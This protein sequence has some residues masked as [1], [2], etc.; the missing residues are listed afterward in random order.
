VAGAVISRAVTHFFRR[1]GFA[2]LVSVVL[3]VYGLEA[4]A[5]REA[6]VT[7]AN[8]GDQAAYL[9]YAKQMHDS[10]YTVVGRRNRMPVFPFLLSL[11][12]RPGLSE[13]QFLTRA[14]SFSIDLSILIL[15]LLFLIFRRFFPPFYA[16]ALLV[17]A[18]F[19]VFVYRSGIVQT[20]VLF[21]FLSFCSFLLLVRML[22]APRWWLAILGG[23]ATGIA[24]LTKASVLPALGLW[25]VVFLAQSSW[26]YRAQPDTRLRE[27]LRRFGLLLLV[28]GTFG[29]VIFPYIRTSKQIFGHYFYNVN[30]TFYMWCDSWPEAVA[31][32]KAYDNS[33][34]GRDFPRDLVPSPGK[35]WREHSAAQIA[36]RLGHGSKTLATRSAK[37][38]GYYKFALLFV[39]TAAALALGRRQLARRLIAEKPFAA[40]FCFLFF[41]SYVLLYAWY[42]AIVSDSRFILSLF[43]PFVF[44]ASTLVLGLGKDRTFAIAG[45]R[46]SFMELFAGCLISLAL[47]DVVYN[48]LR[49]CRLMT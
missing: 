11:N 40:I 45:R 29:A 49:I 20:E 7:P 10:G 35:Y 44:V 34:G 6:I 37:A 32:T 22:I 46:I 24:H 42:D 48:A 1:G 4:H 30:S 18:A 27:A 41:F 39:L 23:A 19:S 3:A 43:L 9:A 38:T 47:I 15:L 17:M 33:R 21:Y 26:E 12:Y 13:T 8:Q 5:R 28:I 25:A 16:L 14:Q 2:L 36:Y 31:F